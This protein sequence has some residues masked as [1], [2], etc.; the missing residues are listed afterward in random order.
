M[1]RR[2]I[3]LLATL[4]LLLSLIMTSTAIAQSFTPVF[5]WTKRFQSSEEVELKVQIGTDSFTFFRSKQTDIDQSTFE[6]LRGETPAQQIKILPDKAN[7]KVGGLSLKYEVNK[8]LRLEETWKGNKPNAW[9][10]IE[11]LKIASY[12][13]NR[14][15]DFIKQAISQ[16]LM[17]YEVIE[18]KEETFAFLTFKQTG[19]QSLRLGKRS[20]NLSDEFYDYMKV[21][22]EFKPYAGNTDKLVVLVHEP[23]WLSAGQYQLIHGLKAYIDTNYQYKFRFLVEGYWEEEIKYIPTKPTLNIFSKDVST[24]AQVFSLLRNFLIDGPFA[25]R[26]LY[27]PDLPA[28]AIDDPNIIKKTPRTPVFKDQFEQQEVFLKIQ[29]KLEKLPKKQRTE[30]SQMLAFLSYYVMADVQNL[31]GEVAIDFYKQLTELYDALSKQLRSIHAQDFKKESS[32]LSNQAENCR[33]QAE[34]SQYALER[35]AVMAKYI[36]NHFESKYAELIPIVFIGNFHTPGIIDRLPKGSSF[37]V[38]EPIV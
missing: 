35:D 4:C 11:F 37:V 20:L 8:L 36:A 21:S 9:R 3:K 24:R 18:Y 22:N 6:S 14:W 32:F 15:P 26:L 31:K 29:E 12:P 10:K 7:K 16:G 17:E 25:Y 1:R 5:E 13:L 28:L 30:A 2:Q 23:H 34:I 33:T 27:N 38:I 19:P